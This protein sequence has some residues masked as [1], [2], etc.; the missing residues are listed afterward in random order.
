MQLN[1]PP[2]A[3]AVI[4]LTSITAA[5]DP[6]PV[7][8]SLEGDTSETVVAELPA[9]LPVESP[10]ES[11]AAINDSF[12]AGSPVLPVALPDQSATPLPA[13]TGTVVATSADLDLLGARIGIPVQGVA[14]GSLRD[15]YTE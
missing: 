4:I 7:P 11:S 8:Y 6:R 14:R 3:L 12:I 1:R 10:V 5:C 2:T 13:D 9:E 15:T